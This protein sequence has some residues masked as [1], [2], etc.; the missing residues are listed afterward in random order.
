MIFASVITDVR[1][2][3]KVT[4]HMNRWFLAL[5]NRLN[6][7]PTSETG[8]SNEA[9]EGFGVDADTAGKGFILIFLSSIIVSP[10]SSPTSAGSFETAIS[11]SSLSLGK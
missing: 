5:T 4:K 6:V 1:Y 10:F 2:T 8:R 3:N 9:V 11:S 7:S